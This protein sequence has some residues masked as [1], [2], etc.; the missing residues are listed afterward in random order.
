MK[1]MKRFFIGKQQI[2]IFI[3]FVFT[4]IAWGQE[5]PNLSGKGTAY[6]PYLITSKNEWDKF[7]A[8]VGGNSGY[9][10]DGKF[11]KLTNDIGTVGDEV[12]VSAGSDEGYFAGHFDGDGHTILFKVTDTE[13]KQYIAPFF[14]VAGRTEASVTN[15]NVTGTITTNGTK[16]AGII[17]L[18]SYDVE[19][20]NCTSNITIVSNTAGSDTH[21]GGLIGEI[22]NNSEIKLENCVFEGTMSGNTTNCAGFIGKIP[23]GEGVRV[24]V[25]YTNCT[26]AHTLIEHDATTVFGTFHLPIDFEPEGDEEAWSTAYFT[27]RVNESDAQGTAAYNDGENPIPANKILK[28]YVRMYAPEISKVFYVPAAE[29]TGL[30]TT[31]YYGTPNPTVTYYGKQLVKGTD[32]TVTI[33]TTSVVNKIMITGAGDFTGSYTKTGVTINAAVRNWANLK[34]ALSNSTAKVIT[35]DI[36]GNYSAQGAEA[37]V[38]NCNVTLDLNGKTID[39]GLYSASKDGTVKTDVQ[40]LKGYVIKINSGKT[41]TIQNGTITGGNNRG[42][43]GESSDDGNGGGIINA[44]NLTLRNVDISNNKVDLCSGY[45]SGNA[46]FWGTGGGIFNSGGSLSIINCTIRDNVCYGGGG[47][48][49]LKSGTLTMSDGTV[50]SGNIADSKGG[51]LRLE[52]KQPITIEGCQII[53]NKAKGTDAPDGAGVYINSS[54]SE[55]LLKNCLIAGNHTLWRGG[56]VYVMGGATVTFE[57]CDIVNNTALGDQSDKETGGGGMLIYNGECHIIGGSITGN[58]SNSAGGIF[59]NNSQNLYVSGD[60]KITGNNGDATRMNVYFYKKKGGTAGKVIIEG[61]I[62][63][64]LIGVSKDEAGAVT[65]GLKGNGT[66]ENFRSDNYELYWLQLDGSNEA[67]LRASL[68]WDKPEEWGDV[69]QE[70]STGV[71]E[72]N[73]PV[74]IPKN[75]TA[76]ATSIT[77]NTGAPSQGAIFIKDGG[78]LVYDGTPVDVACIKSIPKTVSSEDAT[79]WM[80]IS[81]PV[82]DPSIKEATNLITANTPPYDFDLLLYDEPHHYWR[83]YGASSTPFT[84]GKLYNGRGYMYRNSKGLNV[85]YVG[86]TNRAAGGATS[87]NLTYTTDD[88]NPL[89]GFHL[90]GNPFTQNITTS[91]ISLSNGARFTG[92]Y[93]LDGKGGWTSNLEVTLKPADAMLVQIDKATTAT[94]T[95]TAKSRSENEKDFIQFNVANSKYED[96]AY[97]LFEE[98]PGLNKINHLNDKIPMVYIDKNGKDYAIA[99][100]EKNVKTFDLNFKAKTNGRYTLSVKTIGGDYSYLHIIDKLTGKDIDMLLDGEYTFTGSPKDRE[101]RFTVRLNHIGGE[102][103]GDH[104]FAYQSGTDLVVT[105]EGEL[106]VFDTM[107]RFVM[108]RRVSDTET[109]STASLHGL[110][111]LRLVGTEVKTQK[112]VLR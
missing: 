23:T 89:P 6:D 1:K 16:A 44:G 59:V 2:L 10:Y 51:G 111:I 88:D 74:I 28:S 76:T 77:F 107:G 34:T 17:G 64:S 72:I 112:I 21:H 20:K 66:L 86:K 57:N 53:N 93:V 12:S 83:S 43:Q 11:V 99:T 4:T 29:I 48:V 19:I 78:Q 31:L 63:G 79:G 5:M 82:D 85:E 15:L 7:A 69:V 46:S 38:V 18:V 70:T 26:Q 40:T 90:I 54:G 9:H 101:N 81:P 30:N 109:V 42:R 33:D 24:T 92:G 65:S 41:V 58:T 61:N 37:L 39:R 36:D 104:S 75:Y 27:H 97:A 35:F 91:N 45:V 32:Y 25:K 60:V 108:S 100:M 80:L 103:S 49:H 67:S 105:G 102:I 73:A 110:Y 62:G 96:V 3:T 98:G 13:R 50:V 84:G 14:C 95:K 47:G 52:S 94:F 55:R 71:F 56:G 106:Q 22:E 8:Y 68:Y 87:I